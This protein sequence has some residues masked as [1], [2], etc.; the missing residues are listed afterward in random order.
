M[1]MHTWVAC[2]ATSIAIV[3]QDAAYQY[4]TG[5]VN[6]TMQ[7]ITSRLIPYPDVMSSTPCWLLL[8]NVLVRMWWEREGG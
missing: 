3:P 8:G 5:S 1:L 2:R 6:P 7:A 4:L